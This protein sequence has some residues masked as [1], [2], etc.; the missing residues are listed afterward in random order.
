METV[1]V[2]SKYQ[3]VIPARV[4][5]QFRIRPGDQLGVIVT[6]EVFHLAPVRPF[7]SSKG[8]SRGARANLRNLRDH[9]DR[10]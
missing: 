6:H 3:V 5:R 8:V 10:V 4:R 9:A 7:E 1:T 2:S